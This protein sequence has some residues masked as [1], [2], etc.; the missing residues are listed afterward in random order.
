MFVRLKADGTVSSKGFKANY[1][2]GKH[3]KSITKGSDKETGQ[4]KSILE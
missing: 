2:T 1:T 3:L 4:A